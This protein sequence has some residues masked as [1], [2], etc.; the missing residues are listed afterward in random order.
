M[1]AVNIQGE[2]R[3][4]ITKKATRDLR[5][6]GNIPCVLYG[7]KENIHFSIKSKDIKGLVFTPEFKKAEITI[8]GNVHT[9]IVQDIQFN[10]IS[11]K[12][13]HIDFLELT[14]GKKVIVDLPLKFTGVAKGVKAGGKLIPR[15]R[16][17]KVKS[18]PEALASHLD[19]KVEELELGKHIRVKELNFEGMEILTAPN[20]PVVS[21]FVPRVLKTEEVAAPTAAAAPAAG[22]AAPAAA[23]AAAKAPEKKK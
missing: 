16:K 14:P 17:L 9:A 19:I 13:N 6:S 10:T 18:T 7:G 1:L 8:G 12:V 20:N 5:S 2:V 11:D 21:A 4:S 15:L 3:N 23:P 22:A